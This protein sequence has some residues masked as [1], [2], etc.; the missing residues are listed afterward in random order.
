MNG[1]RRQACEVCKG[2]IRQRCIFLQCAEQSA[3]KAIKVCGHYLR[4]AATYCD[5]FPQQDDSSPTSCAAGS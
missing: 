3:V 5:K 1:G 4:D 2:I